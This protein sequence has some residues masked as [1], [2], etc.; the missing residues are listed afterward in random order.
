MNK[1]LFADDCWKRKDTTVDEIV[2]LLWKIVPSINLYFTIINDIHTFHSTYLHGNHSSISGN[3][4]TLPSSHSKIGLRISSLEISVVIIVPK[5]FSTPKES[6][7]AWNLT[8]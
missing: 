8:I 6:T 5:Y 3:W 7:K 2:A 1:S 4:E